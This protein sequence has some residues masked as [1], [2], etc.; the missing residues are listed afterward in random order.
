MATCTRCGH[1]TAASFR[2]CDACLAE[3]VEVERVEQGLPPTIEDPDTIRRL[4]A[5]S[6]PRLSEAS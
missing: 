4:A 2:L 5:L 6:A 3:R 1:P